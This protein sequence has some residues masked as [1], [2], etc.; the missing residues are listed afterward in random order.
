MFEVKEAIHLPPMSSLLL[1]KYYLDDDVEKFRQLLL[2][3]GGPQT[4]KSYGVL[5][6]AYGIGAVG[7]PGESFGGYL[8]YGEL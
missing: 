1:W 2:S 3:N 4:T 6:G 7:S 5:Q 8:C